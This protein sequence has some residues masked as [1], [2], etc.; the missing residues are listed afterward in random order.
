MSV[1]GDLMAACFFRVYTFSTSWY[2]IGDLV[3]AC[4]LVYKLLQAGTTYYKVLI[5]QRNLS[6]N[7]QGVNIAVSIH[8]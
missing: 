6:V 4:F 2:Q 3:T 8:I 5:K 1:V 7:R